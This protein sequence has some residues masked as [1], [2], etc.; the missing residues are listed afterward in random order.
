[1]KG[2]INLK[3]KDHKCFMW[4]NFRLINPTNSHPKRINKQD[5][6]IAANLTYSDIEFPLD[7]NDY[8][9]I[10]NRFEMNI[11]VFGYEH[12]VYPLYISKTP[13]TQTL[14]LLLISQ[15]NKSHYV[16]IKDFNRLMHLKTKDQHKKHHF[17]SC[18]QRFAKEE[19]L[20]QHKNNA[21]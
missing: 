11:N 2:L 16:L 14:N 10:E 3:N 15:E 7:I 8:E 18:L 9:L 21:Y 13:H 5:K 20:N 4:C 19:I 6:R 12:K 1:M 17:L